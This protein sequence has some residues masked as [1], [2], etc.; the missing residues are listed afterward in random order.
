MSN[1]DKTTST[2]DISSV[3]SEQLFTELTPEQAA[4]IE[5][6]VAL[7][8]IVDGLQAIKAGADGFPS[9]NDDTYLTVNGRQ[10]GGEI[11][12]TTGQYSTIGLGATFGIGNSARVE[13][14][15][16][17]SGFNG[18]DDNLGGF[19]VTGTTNGQ[20]KTRVSGSGSIYDVYYR[21]FP[22]LNGAVLVA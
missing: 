10:L 12:F 19:T 8:L 6:G 20:V 11:G 15:D 13:L 16:A 1:F 7:F 5:G 18:K 2:S 3:G 21:V 22:S 9:G 4:V 17:D 14:F